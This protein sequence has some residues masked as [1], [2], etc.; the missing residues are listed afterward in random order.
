MKKATKW[1]G[2][3]IVLVLVML[4]LVP[5]VAQ[6]AD[7]V[8]KYGGPSGQGTLIYWCPRTGITN[9]VCESN[10]VSGITLAGGGTLVTNVV[11]QRQAAPSM[12]NVATGA[13]AA[14]SMTNIVVG[15]QVSPSMTNISWATQIVTNFDGV[16][17][18]I[19]TNY[20]PTLQFTA[21]VAVTSVTP[22]NAVGRALTNVTPQNATVNAL[23]NV[24]VQNP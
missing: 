15:Y 13:Q 1:G 10:G 20:V 9:F 17:T 21:N 4:A 3:L 19:Y 8:V 24:T 14:P 16:G 23:T 2:L 12:T 7:V 5:I 11:L 18:N 6:S 22:Q